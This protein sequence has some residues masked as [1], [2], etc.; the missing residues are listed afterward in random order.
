M[1]ERGWVWDLV[2][3][4]SGLAIGWVLS[5]GIRTAYDDI[6]YHKSDEDKHSGEVIVIEE[7]Q[8]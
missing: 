1:N 3:L 7:K 8:D 2:V 5:A 4:G 6:K